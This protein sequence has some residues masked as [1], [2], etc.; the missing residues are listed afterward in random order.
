MNKRLDLSVIILTFNEELH[1]G[2]ALDNVCGIVEHVYVIDCF[3]TDKTKEICMKYD[4]VSVVEHKWPGNQAAQFNWGLDN[5]D[6]KTEWCLRLDADEYLTEELINELFLKLPQFQPNVSA[7]VIPLGRGFMGK[8]LKHTSVSKMIRLFRTGKARY[9][10][11]IMDEHLQI[12]SG[13]TI[14]FAN[15]FI[16]DNLNTLSY[17]ID[18]HNKYSDREVIQSLDQEYG[19]TNCCYD[20]NVAYCGEVQG[21][22]SQKQKYAKMPLFWRSLVYFLYRYVV[23]GGFLDGKAGFCWCFFQGLWYRML[24][25]GKIYSI[26]QACS[27]DKEEIRKYLNKHYNCDL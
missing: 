2:R 21:I 24:V 16:D 18:K 6:I 14:T 3:S 23:V 11:S 15:P 1:I 9:D 25:D 12:T 4:N 20:G 19:F 22:K 7:G 27:N 26:K 13:T 5:I 10:N 8:R 17:F